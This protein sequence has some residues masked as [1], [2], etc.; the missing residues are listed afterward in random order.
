M[1]VVIGSKYTPGKTLEFREPIN[2]FYQA[3]M[4]PPQADMLA[5]QRALTA[6][7]VKRSL[8]QKLMVA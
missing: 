6:K 7:P 4:M 5:L 3:V 2:G 8:W 1:K